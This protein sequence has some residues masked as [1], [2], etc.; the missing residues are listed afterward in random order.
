MLPWLRLRIGNS[1]NG[2]AM[3]RK[4]MSDGDEK[5]TNIYREKPHFQVHTTNKVWT[6]EYPKCTSYENTAFLLIWSFN[7][8]NLHAEP[9]FYRLA[10]LFSLNVQI[11]R[12]D[13]PVPSL[14]QPLW[15][16]VGLYLQFVFLSTTVFNGKIVLL[17]H[18]QKFFLYLTLA[19]LQ[20]NCQHDQDNIRKKYLSSSFFFFT[21]EENSKF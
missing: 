10:E 14:P 17:S 20:S 16:T 7:I 21:A 19:V 2:Y 5:M 11:H 3:K 15:E 12:L 18:V 1:Q 8:Q 9:C 13:L 4:Q 6:S